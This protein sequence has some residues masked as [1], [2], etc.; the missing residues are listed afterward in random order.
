MGDPYENEIRENMISIMNELKENYSYSLCFQSRIGPLKW[1]EPS[2]EVEIDR[3]VTK[4]IDKIIV[5]P[6]SFVSENLE[7]LYELDIQKK[8]YALRR[9]MKKFIRVETIQHSPHFTD[10]LF[11]TISEYCSSQDTY[12]E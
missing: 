10:Y 7:T 3:L 4:K 11:N 6:I 1:L 5:F 8:K 9:G 12:S 2:V